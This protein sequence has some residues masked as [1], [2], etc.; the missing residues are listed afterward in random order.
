VL[1][2]ANTYLSPHGAHNPPSNARTSEG[3]PFSDSSQFLPFSATSIKPSCLTVGVCPAPILCPPPF[4]NFSHQTLFRST[5]DLP[6]QMSLMKP[7]SRFTM[8]AR[9]IRPNCPTKWSPG[10]LPLRPSRLSRTT[11]ARRA[12]RSTTPL[13]RNCSSVLL[14]PKSTSWPRPRVL[15]TGIVK[16][17]CCLFCLV[18]F[19]FHV[20]L[21]QYREINET[22]G[23]SMRRRRT[24]SICMKNNMAA[25]N[26]T[27]PTTN[28]TNATSNSSAAIGRAIS[29][30]IP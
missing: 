10:V 26:T 19:F 17:M 11:S 12:R 28:T 18:L 3:F 23:P 13:P 8:M 4:L 9:S 30:S 24:Q 20:V 29:M 2:P 1:S 15:T 16:G 25:T 27:T 22:A 5:N 21:V 14:A 7:T 6:L